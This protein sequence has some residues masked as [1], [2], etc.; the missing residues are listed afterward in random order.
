[1]IQD[2]FCLK[3]INNIDFIPSWNKCAYFG[4]SKSPQ[5][6]QQ[7]EWKGLQQKPLLPSWLE[8]NF[9]FRERKNYINNRFYE[10][11]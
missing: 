6:P 11:C 8:S 4:N 3:I 7:P 5:V 1:M 2:V 10:K 9:N